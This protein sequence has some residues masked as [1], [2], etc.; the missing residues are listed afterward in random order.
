MKGDPQAQVQSSRDVSRPSTPESIRHNAFIAVIMWSTC[1]ISMILMNKVIL[2]T[3]SFE[4]NVLLL[5]YQNSL[6]VIVMFVAKTMG[7][8]E[9]EE[10]KFKKVKNWLPLDVFFVFMLYSGTFSLKYLSVPMVTVFKN[11]NNIVITFADFL[12]YRNLVSKGTLLSLLLMLIA[13]VL[14]S[15][16]DLE[17]SFHGYIWTFANCTA[18]A[19]FVLYMP[20]AMSS[21]SLSPLGKVFYNNILSLP[22]LVLLDIFTY[23]DIFNVLKKDNPLEWPFELHVLLFISGILGF[24]LSLTA[25]RCMQM[26]S[27]TTYALVGSINKIPLTL[28]GIFIFQTTVTLPGGVYVSLSMLA[29]GVFGYSK[30]IEKEKNL[31]YASV[32]VEQK[33]RRYRAETIEEQNVPWYP[34]EVGRPR[35]R[36]NS[37]VQKIIESERE[38]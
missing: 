35:R 6:C 30:A 3:Y 36:T 27:P 24:F 18:T 37:T 21:T 8:I 29:A 4:Y 25:F 38:I 2:T 15:M 26:T 23:Q 9:L 34:E 28:I 31:G 17:Y 12:I 10:L 7:F 13:A 32:S 22:L 19:A 20:R 14:S 5:L 16:E 33:S 1:S 11:M